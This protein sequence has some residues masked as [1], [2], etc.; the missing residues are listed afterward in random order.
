MDKDEAK[1]LLGSFR[2]D[3]ADAGDEDFAAALQLAA[4]DRELGEWL[5]GERSMD[6]A[7]AA[8]LGSVAPP[9]SL[10]DDILGLET[11]GFGGIPQAETGLDAWMIGSLASMAAPEGLRG[12]V[13]ASMATTAQP[14]QPGAG[15]WRKAAWPVAA[16]AGVALAFLFTID[17]S[18]DPLPT[19]AIIPAST[20]VPV[21]VVQASFIRTFESPLFGFDEHRQPHGELVEILEKKKLPCARRLPPGLV[22]VQCE[23]CREMVIDGK[24]G[25]LV[26]FDDPVNGRVHLVIFKRSDVC[27]EL[28]T[29][30]NPALSQNGPWAVAR[31]IDGDQVYV[32]LG[33]RPL[34]K[35]A[36]LF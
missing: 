14:R 6:A 33:S 7:F 19:A 8:A 16:A 35:L 3:G 9:A 34:E 17:R 4:E 21:D 13:L 23:G 2:P 22:G 27:G 12:R 31:W 1:F 30:D 36:T 11:T 15:W 24:R 18:V 29:R 10:R 20:T 26:C 28:P 25:S 5:A 32:L